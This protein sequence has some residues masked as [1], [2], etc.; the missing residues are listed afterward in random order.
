MWCVL[1]GQ[2]DRTAPMQDGCRV[3]MPAELE[4]ESLYD[5]LDSEQSPVVSRSSKRPVT[6]AIVTTPAH[7]PGRAPI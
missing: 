5:I 3:G 4:A 7:F 6:V 2:F 1:E